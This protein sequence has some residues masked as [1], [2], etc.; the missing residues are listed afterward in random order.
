MVEIIEPAINGLSFNVS[1]LTY[2]NQI[3]LDEQKMCL[4]AESVETEN[5]EVE[6]P[7]DEFVIQDISIV[8]KRIIDSLEKD[9]IHRMQGINTNT[10]QFARNTRNSLCRIAWNDNWDN[11]EFNCETYKVKEKWIDDDQL[12][13]GENVGYIQHNPNYIFYKFIDSLIRIYFAAEYAFESRLKN[14]DIISMVGNQKS[15]IKNETVIHKLIS[16]LNGLL[17][18]NGREKLNIN[19]GG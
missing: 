1:E 6:D 13:W 14:E 16:I 12:Y 9:E 18:A 17:N 2:E 11:I 5:N 4:D 8:L 19:F 10:P 15:R 3:S 7:R